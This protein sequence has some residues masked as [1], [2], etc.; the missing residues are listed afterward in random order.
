MKIVMITISLKEMEQIKEVLLPL[1][2]CLKGM[3]EIIK[4]E[5]SKN[6]PKQPEPSSSANTETH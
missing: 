6:V 4:E 1:D 2:S 3:N 5:R